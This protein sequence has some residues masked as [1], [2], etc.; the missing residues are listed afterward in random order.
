MNYNSHLLRCR[1]GAHMENRIR[2]YRR[3]FIRNLSHGGRILRQAGV[4]DRFGDIYCG[5]CC[6]VESI[7]Y[8][9]LL[10]RQRVPL[11]AGLQLNVGNDQK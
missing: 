2:K 5:G 7:R 6:R 4:I 3:A 8:A 10:E 9:P 11:Q 1:A